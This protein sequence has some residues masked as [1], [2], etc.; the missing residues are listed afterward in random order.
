MSIPVN[1]DTG[2]C[3]GTKEEQASSM[4][5]EPQVLHVLKYF[6]LHLLLKDK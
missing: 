1:G 3:S 5:R 2:H 4:G 6:Q